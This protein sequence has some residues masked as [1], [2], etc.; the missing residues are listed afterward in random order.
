MDII[1]LGVIILIIDSIYLH[2]FSGFFNK[3][4]NDIQ[5]SDI[6]LKYDGAILCYITMVLGLKY[7]IIDE[8][9][10]IK[11]AFLLG[12]LI[13]SVFEFTNYAILD[14][15]NLKAVLIDSIWGGILFAIST[16]LYYV[17]LDYKK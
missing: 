15:W 10:P 17:Y 2:S 5:G 7:F 3:I 1:V 6:K 8:K 16:Y 4:V 12:L 9:K 13:Y 11:D 14:K